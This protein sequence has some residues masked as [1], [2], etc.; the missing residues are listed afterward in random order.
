MFPAV[1]ARDGGKPKLSSYLFTKT[2]I[3]KYNDDL[4]L[5]L[6]LALVVGNIERLH[7]YYYRFGPCIS[8]VNYP[9]FRELKCNYPGTGLIFR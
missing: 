2:K 3:H 6:S 9:V 1:R 4:G 8:K 5:P 7:P